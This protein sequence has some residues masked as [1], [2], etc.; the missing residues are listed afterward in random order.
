MKALFGA[1]TI[2]CEEREKRNFR[3]DRRLTG[4]HRTLIDYVW[5]VVSARLP[6]CGHFLVCPRL[7]HKDKNLNLLV[8]LTRR[9]PS[10]K[11]S[12]I[13]LSARSVI[14]EGSLNLQ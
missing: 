12:S 3:Q 13:A 14:N 1:M 9:I 4:K 7:H 6:R 11:G 2:A 5:W 10:A 8:Y